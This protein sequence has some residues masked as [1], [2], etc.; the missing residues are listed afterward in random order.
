MQRELRGSKFIIRHWQE[1]AEE[2]RGKAEKHQ[3][4]VDH[5]VKEIKKRM[6]K[7]ELLN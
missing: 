5:L 6:Q 2:W 7:V 4:E 1:V 3:K